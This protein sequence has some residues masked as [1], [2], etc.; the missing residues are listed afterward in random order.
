MLLGVLVSAQARINNA[1]M[2]P[3]TRIFTKEGEDT[4]VNFPSSYLDYYPKINVIF[5]EG[6]DNPDARFCSVYII[7]GEEMPRSALYDILGRKDAGRCVYVNVRLNA[8]SSSEELLGFLT[9][10][11]L[12]YVEVNYKTGNRS[13]DRIILAAEGYGVSLISALAPLSEYFGNF[14]LSFYTN[15]AMPE[16]SDSVRND[17]SLWLV[18]TSGNMLRLQNKLEEKGLKF[19]DNFAY[20]TVDTSP[21]EKPS[22]K[23]IFNLSYFLDKEEFLPLKGKG[24]L[25]VKSASSS[26]EESFGFKVEIK[27]RKGFKAEYIPSVLKIAPPFLSWDASK[28]LMSV[29]YG[30]QPGKVKITGMAG[31]AASFDASFKITK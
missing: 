20:L 30:A 26:S 23:N 4:I 10:D 5:P 27:G 14:A 29:I 1:S 22:L 12:P 3:D 11:L 13:S 16:I 15:T 31:D 18:G 2:E 24:I 25:S 21:G 19:F 6:Y 9:R 17:V 28:G 7:N 8:S